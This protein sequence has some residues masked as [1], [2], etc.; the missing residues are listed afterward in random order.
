MQEFIKLTVGARPVYLRSSLIRVWDAGDAGLGSYVY[1]S[2]EL[3]LAVQESPEEIAA[4]L[5]QPPAARPVGENADAVL[6]LAQELFAIRQA[7]RVKVMTWPELSL[8]S[9][10]GWLAVA[11]HVLARSVPA[12]CGE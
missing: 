1:L 4:L 8:Q 2:D 6:A 5:F 7:G 9:Q 11:R 10:A 12:Y 3:P